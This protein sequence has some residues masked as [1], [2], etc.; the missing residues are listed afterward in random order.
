MTR[1]T[2]RTASRRIYLGGRAR[3][4]RITWPLRGVP[5]VII[6]GAMKAGTTSLA[7][8]LEQ[9][10]QL[11]PAFK[12]EVHFFDGGADPDDDTFER[13][14]SWYR[15]HFPIR[16]RT[17][18]GTLMFEASPLYLFSPLAAGRIRELLPQARLIALLRHPTDRAISHVRHEQRT[19]TEPL[20]LAAALAAEDD[21]L[22][23]S[24]RDRDFSTFEFLH[25]SYE[26]RGRYDEQLRRYSELFPDRQ[27]LAI[28]SETFFTDTRSTLARVFDF[29]G[30][31][32]R[33]DTIDLTPQN[34]SPVATPVDPGLRSELD[35]HFEPHIHALYEL[36]GDDFGW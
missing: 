25:Y 11:C 27:I 16:H 2:V 3:A 31:D 1:R 22:A 20:D 12:K 13:G 17:R 7:H 35:A 26:R 5:D 24:L 32:D 19:G 23:P 14:A 33:S 4:R 21:R 9:H 29:L 15:S 10:P 6:V 34:M 18:H 36:L 30:V 28:D 8:H